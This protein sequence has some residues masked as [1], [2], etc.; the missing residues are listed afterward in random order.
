MN[1]DRR[2]KDRGNA[3]KILAN[4]HG[5][6]EFASPVVRA[7]T[8]GFEHRAELLKTSEMRNHRN[9][10]TRTMLDCNYYDGLDVDRSVHGAFDI[11]KQK[12]DRRVQE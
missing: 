7:E 10:Y 9:P 3:A 5:G 4:A 12:L 1:D 8:S 6:H 11:M 2:E